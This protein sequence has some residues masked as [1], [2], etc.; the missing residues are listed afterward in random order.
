MGS[1]QKMAIDVN[2]FVDII[3]KGN[4]GKLN[5]LSFRLLLVSGDCMGGRKES[6]NFKK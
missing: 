3:R 4:F 6:P 2:F 5:E 1:E